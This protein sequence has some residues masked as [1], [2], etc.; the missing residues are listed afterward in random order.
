MNDMVDTDALSEAAGQSQ[1]VVPGGADV[2]KK[3]KLF[4]PDG[5]DDLT[6]RQMIGGNSTNIL[7]LN[8]TKYKWAA[9]LKNAMLA[10]F[11][12]PEKNSLQSDRFSELT[13]DQK[14]TFVGILSFLI[15]LDSIQTS[16]VPN[17]ADYITAPEVKV[18]LAIQT[19]QEA[20]HADSYQY[21]I[22]SLIP[23]EMRNGIYD[24]W[25]NDAILF[26]RNR[27]I[28]G[29]FQS[30]LD[31]PTVYGFKRVLMA[32]F[33]LESLYFYNGFQFFYLLASQGL[34]NGTSRIIK[35]IN[36][37]ELT[38]VTLFKN[39]MAEVLTKD[40]HGWARE[41]TAQA[42]EQEI[43]FSHHVIGD[44]ILGM[45]CASSEHYTKH[46]A[47]R[48]LEAIRMEPLYTGVSDNP[49]RHLEERAD[50][51]GEGNAK[52]SFFTDSAAY[53]QSNAVGGFD[54]F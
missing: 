30:F 10:N 23:R 3:A 5:V 33:L 4:N 22:E 43:K 46:L 9:P 38:H 26:E 32:N 15:F 11:W 35:L 52:G 42:V 48:R 24:R 21:I 19:Y 20:I 16:N 31:N 36:K 7:Q 6:A 53:N 25:R 37:D 12:I 49:Y 14:D 2:I 8:N 1:I 54:K 18:L 47:N 50:M 17:I 51:H 41:M 28:A 29:E 40:D 34:M 39:I 27:L 13:A 45:S 44:R